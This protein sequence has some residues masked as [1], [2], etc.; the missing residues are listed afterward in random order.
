MTEADAPAASIPVI[1]RTPPEP[2]QSPPDTPAL[3]TYDLPG[4]RQIVT[5]GLSLA[6][7]A[8]SELRRASPDELGAA[9]DANAAR[10]FGW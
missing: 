9:M 10:V 4:A 5:F 7:R 6:F 2:E 8:T 1:P 3:R